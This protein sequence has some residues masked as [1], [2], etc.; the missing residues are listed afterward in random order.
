MSTTTAKP[1]TPPTASLSLSGSNKTDLHRRSL[2]G[3]NAQPR[4][5]GGGEAWAASEARKLIVGREISVSGEISCCDVLMIEGTVEARLREGR[6]MEVAETGTF[7][8]SVEIAE[9]EIA[10][11]F[12]GELTVHGRLR[13]RASGR[14]QGVIRYAELEVDVGG[15]VLGDVQLV[16]ATTSPVP[17]PMPVESPPRLAGFPAVPPASAADRE[18]VANAAS[19]TRGG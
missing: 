2:D 9:A 1:P 13:V 3:Q 7:K 5:S 12:E 17:R 4:R 8:G 6:Y 19:G 16:P 11:H 14:V 10:G 18:A 15:Q